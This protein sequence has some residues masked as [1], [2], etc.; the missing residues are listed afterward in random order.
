VYELGAELDGPP[1]DGIANG[2]DAP[3]YAVARVEDVNVNA[4]VVQRTRGGKS[5]GTRPNHDDHG[6]KCTALDEWRGT[7]DGLTVAE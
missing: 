7:T 5:G 2:E 1:C 6:V 4:V 3:A